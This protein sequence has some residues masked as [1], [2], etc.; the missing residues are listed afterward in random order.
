MLSYE[1]I[2]YVFMVTY[3]GEAHIFMEFRHIFKI[4]IM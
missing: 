4:F 2:L 1:V 3:Q